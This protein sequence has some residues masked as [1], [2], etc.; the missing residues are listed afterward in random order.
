MDCR[1][2]INEVFDG[3]H[4]DRLPRALFGS[5]LRAYNHIGL[6]PEELRTKTGQVVEGLSSLYGRLDTDMLFLG[7][8]L[9][10]LP[11]EAIGRNLHFRGQQAPLLDK[12][13]TC[14]FNI[15]NRR[16]CRCHQGHR[17]G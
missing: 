14:S 10:S 4:H 1:A 12:P 3:R 2:Y 5:G 7:S 17:E 8:G 11:A 6:R 16:R 9:N 13:V 15:R